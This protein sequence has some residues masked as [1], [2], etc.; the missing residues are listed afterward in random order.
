MYVCICKAVTD[1]QIR[2]AVRQGCR[3][4]K[5]VVCRLNVGKDCGKCRGDVRSLL[6]TL[7]AETVRS[8]G[9]SRSSRLDAAYRLKAELQ[10]PK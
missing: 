2:E 4:R 7:D 1:G 9:F 6:R 10:T 8:S 3:T 5:D